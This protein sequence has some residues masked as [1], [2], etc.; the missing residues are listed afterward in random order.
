MTLLL[1][2]LS[3][4]TAELVRTSGWV[5]VGVLLGIGLLAL[6]LVRRPGPV[7][8][9]AVSVILV[10]SVAGSTLILRDR[11]FY[12][13]YTVRQ[14]GEVRVF[15][16]GTTVHGQQADG[17]RRYEPSTYFARSGPIGRAFAAMPDASDV[18]V[19]GLGVGTIAAYGH[20]GQNLTFYEI[21]SD[22]VKVASNPKLFT[23]VKDSKANIEVAVVDGR[24]GIESEPV[25]SY[26]VLILDA[27]ASDSIPVHL[28]T[29]E[30]MSSY[31]DVLRENGLLMVHISNR[32]FDLEPVL[33]GGAEAVGWSAMVGE[34]VADEET[35]ATASVWVAMSEDPGLL[36]RLATS[37]RWRPIGTDI[38]TWTD[39]YS[40]VLSV[41]R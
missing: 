17:A 5:A 13:A 16:H 2:G 10:F 30:A 31:S 27:F 8:L 6:L 25:S 39:D 7:A 34:G 4:G 22:V 20:V 12:G 37:G 35:G 32:V 36:A 11:S 38:V 41:L 23:Y 3:L 18:A 14:V 15:A 24:L 28:L 33:A 9:G 29:R 40:S 21:D 19:V 26:D 1:M